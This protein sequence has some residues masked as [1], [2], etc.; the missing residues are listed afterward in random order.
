MIA[1]AAERFTKNLWSERASG[2]RPRLVT[3]T[4]EAEQARYVADRVLENRERGSCAQGAGGAVSHLATTRPR[5][6][7]SWRGAAF[8]SSS[9]AA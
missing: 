5:S 3:V 2:D 8:R 9:S 6:R 1:L 7:S 4:D